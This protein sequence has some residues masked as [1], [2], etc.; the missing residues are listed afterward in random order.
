MTLDISV[1]S[2]EGTHIVSVSG[3]IDSANAAG[4][5]KDVLTLFEV[6]GS[7][8][9]MD[10]AGLNYISS[11]GLRVVLMAVKRAKQGQGRLVFFGMQP[12]VREVFQMSGFLTILEVVDDQAA[13]IATLAASSAR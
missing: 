4:L 3:R 1:V 13:A 9:L 8:V 5:Q 6:P 11:A 10:M 12:M 7:R 2:A